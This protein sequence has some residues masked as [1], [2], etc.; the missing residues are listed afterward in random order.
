MI[1]M[2]NRSF[3]VSIMVDG[4]MRLSRKYV[5]PVV[6]VLQCSPVRGKRIFVQGER[7]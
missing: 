2:R 5:C 1:Y 4:Y 3:Y 7:V 6:N